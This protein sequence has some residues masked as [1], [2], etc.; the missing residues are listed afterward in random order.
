MHVENMHNIQK[1]IHIFKNLK[2]EFENYWTD[3]YVHVEHKAF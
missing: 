3:T 2:T 1:Y